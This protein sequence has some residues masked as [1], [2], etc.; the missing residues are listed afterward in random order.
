[1]LCQ[2]GGPNARRFKQSAKYEFT[3]Y[4]ME[5]RRKIGGIAFVAQKKT[6]NS[7]IVEDVS[8][9]TV[10]DIDRLLAYLT[11]TIDDSYSDKVINS[12]ELQ[13]DSNTLQH[14]VISANPKCNEQEM[15]RLIQRLV[16]YSQS[17]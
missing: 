10:E 12:T 13:Q 8:V 6:K 15:Q 4:T 3:M 9:P 11:D 14:N 2:G 7:P 16:P 5:M 1:M 17:M